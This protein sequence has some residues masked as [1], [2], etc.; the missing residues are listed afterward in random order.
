MEIVSVGYRYRKRLSTPFEFIGRKYCQH[1]HMDVDACKEEGYQDNVFAIKL[2]C[3]RCGK[4]IAG[5]VH[6]A[7]PVIECY[8]GSRFSLALE[9]MKKDEHITK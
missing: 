2:W 5:G 8:P 7:A 1:C 4:V 9:W 6:F 3:R